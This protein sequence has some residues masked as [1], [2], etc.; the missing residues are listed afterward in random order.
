VRFAYPGYRSA[1]SERERE[2]DR[3]PASGRSLTGEQF[4]RHPGAGRDP[5]PRRM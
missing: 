3:T 5:G 1:H 2:R 4:H